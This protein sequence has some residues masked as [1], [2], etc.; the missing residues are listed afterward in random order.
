MS[1][2]ESI[3]RFALLVP[4]AAL[5]L[6]TGCGGGGDK[7][8][9]GPGGGETARFALMSVGKA[10]LPADVKVED[11]TLTRFYGGEMVVTDDGGWELRLQVHDGNYGDWTSG[12]KGE[13]EDDGY[14]LWFVSDYSGS[15]YPADVEGTEIKMMYDWCYNEVPDIQLVLDR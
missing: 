10:G 7:G 6:G 4:C 9:T 1:R 2:I 11:C 5:L 3:R 12:D 13:I 8:P 14:N 15:S